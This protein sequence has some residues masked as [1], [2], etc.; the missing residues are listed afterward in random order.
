[1]WNGSLFQHL[2]SKRKCPQSSSVSL[3]YNGDKSL[4][5]MLFR[6]VFCFFLPACRTSAHLADPEIALRF[7]HLCL[8][9]CVSALIT[10]AVITSHH[11]TLLPCDFTLMATLST[12]TVSS[13]AQLWV[14]DTKEKRQHRCKAEESGYTRSEQLLVMPTEQLT[15]WEVLPEEYFKSI[16]MFE[17]LAGF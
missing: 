13:L 3:E 14:H 5:I 4:G 15:D 6:F 1:M 17:G 16:R 7:P 8:L 11:Y 12:A 10:C 9:V 2:F